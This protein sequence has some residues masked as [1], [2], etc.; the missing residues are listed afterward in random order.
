MVIAFKLIA[1]IAPGR[2]TS[3]PIVANVSRQARVPEI[4]FPGSGAHKQIAAECA[5]YLAVMNPVTAHLP[6]LIG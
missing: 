2:G 4:A 5:N 6:D 1:K 3:T